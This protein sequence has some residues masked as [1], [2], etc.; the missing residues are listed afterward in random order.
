MYQTAIRREQSN[1]F[2][3]EMARHLLM[4]IVVAVAVVI[5]NLTTLY[6]LRELAQ[7]SIQQA[8]LGSDLYKQA[9]F[10]A[11]KNHD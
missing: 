11:A 4:L 7:H 10:D 2:F 6:V 1:G 5:G 9:Q 8:I 3:S